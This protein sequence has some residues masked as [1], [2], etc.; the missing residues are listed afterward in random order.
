LVSPTSYV[1]KF[2]FFLSTWVCLH[3]LITYCL[4]AIRLPDNL[5]NA[6][7]E[8]TAESKA[9]AIREESTFAAVYT[10]LTHIPPS[11][12]EPT[13]APPDHPDANV[14]H[15]PLEDMY[16]YQVNIDRANAP[17]P[18][19]PTDPAAMNKLIAAA[20]SVLQ[21]INGV[22][23]AHIPLQ[24]PAAPP[25]TNTK[26]SVDLSLVGGLLNNPR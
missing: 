10:S 17:P 19:P 16:S 24:A 5:V 26:R 4:L 7:P 13:E 9:Q 15:I 23:Q 3:Y 6:I 12:A 11:P 18:P 2:P 14:L 8:E 1:L 20:G 25:P 21:S 22:P